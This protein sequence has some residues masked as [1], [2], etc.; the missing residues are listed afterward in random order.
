[1]D[2]IEWLTITELARRLRQNGYPIRRHW[3]ACLVKTD[4]GLPFRFS[5]ERF[6]KLTLLT[7]WPDA[8]VWFVRYRQKIISSAADAART[9]RQPQYRH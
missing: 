6:N 2:E 3:L 5:R 1:M 7:P 9:G 4:S 8:L